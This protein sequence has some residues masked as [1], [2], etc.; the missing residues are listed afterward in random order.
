MSEEI[1]KINLYYGWML[2]GMDY[3]SQGFL[4]NLMNFREEGMIQYINQSTAVQSI[5]LWACT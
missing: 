1:S 3:D 5:F 4:D 2:D